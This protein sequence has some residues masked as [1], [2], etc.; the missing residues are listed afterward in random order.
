MQESHGFFT[1]FEAAAD[2]V[3]ASLVDD[4]YICS[5]A[6]VTTNTLAAILGGVAG[7][8][9]CVVIDMHAMVPASVYVFSLCEHC[10]CSF[11]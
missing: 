11:Q 10:F 8:H 6:V 1:G 3:V 5:P 2:T 9:G 4:G 7:F